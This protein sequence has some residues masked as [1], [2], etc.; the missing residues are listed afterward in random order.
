MSATGLDGGT[1]GQVD[2]WM[3]GQMGGTEREKGEATP[4]TVKGATELLGHQLQAL[5]QL[6]DSHH[7]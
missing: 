5:G 3:G 4:G 6:L 7:F 1:G 2:G